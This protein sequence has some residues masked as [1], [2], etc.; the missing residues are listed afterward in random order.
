[1][2]QRKS[3]ISGRPTR[4]TPEQRWVLGLSSLASF[5]VILDALVVATALTAIRRHLGASLGDLEWTV[6]A[7][8]LSFAVLLMTAAAFGNRLGR[9]RVFAAGLGLFAVSSAACALA[10]DAGALIAAR[11]VQGAG[12]AM[13]MPTA[14]ALLNGAFPP[15]RRGW[16]IGI[17]GSVTALAAVLGPVFGGAV[18]QGLGWPW[19][20]WLNVPVGLVAIPL[21]LTRLRET[22]GA[23]GT[24]DVPGLLLVTAAALGLVWGLVRGNSAGWGS[25]ETAGSLVAGT[26]AALAFVAWERRAASPMLPLRLF[27]A[28]AFSAG[29]AAIFLLNASLTGAIFLMPQFQQVVLGQDP[30]RAGLRLL[31]WGIVPFLIA[32]RAGA[33]ADRVGARP[34]VVT[35]LLGQ[36][37][38]MAWIAA[39]ATPG[40][41]YWTLVVP[42][43]MSGAA[44]GLAIPAL[45]RSVTS[46]VAAADMGTAS[47]AFSTM[48]QL[49]GAF[50]VAV[51]GAAFAAT[52]NYASPSAFNSGFVTASIVGAGIA[53]AGAAVGMVLPRRGNRPA[54]VAAGELEP[55]RLVRAAGVMGDLGSGELG[56]GEVASGELVSDH[57]GSGDSAGAPCG[58]AGTAG[59]AAGATR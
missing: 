13:I 59:G 16:A 28:R 52:G 58:A 31:P 51:F 9:R 44:L 40:V 37:A 36:A 14:L 8:T 57:L 42:M 41:S 39:I 54:P 19:V 29:N 23:G 25:G 7:Y 24:V 22:A 3:E 6:N 55:G 48:R 17:Y 18:T 1:M 43:C 46:T 49:G 20:F 50:G 30:F 56:S 47:G 38:G 26:V 34:L 35:G 12:A 32:P 5:M 33:L 27:R 4:S 11:A 45:T 53:L 15:A 2:L 10:P 21:V